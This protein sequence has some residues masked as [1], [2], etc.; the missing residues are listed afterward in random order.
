[1]A[2][3]TLLEGGHP[4]EHEK[5]DNVLWL[6]WKR[7]EKDRRGSRQA[8]RMKKKQTAPLGAADGEDNL[9]ASSHADRYGENR[10]LSALTA[11]MNEVGQPPK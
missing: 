10:D 5:S 3:L 1:M 4:G 7:E 2:T 11:G 6:W 9:R 8:P